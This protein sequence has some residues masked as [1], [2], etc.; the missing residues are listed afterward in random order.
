MAIG[1]GTKNIYTDLSLE[2]YRLL[3]PPPPP[4]RRDRPL[5]ISTRILEPQHR[6]K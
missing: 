1:F 4:P 3:P 6:L 5:D 2:E